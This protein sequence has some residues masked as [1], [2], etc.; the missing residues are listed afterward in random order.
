MGKVIVRDLFCAVRN[1][2]MTH[3][4]QVASVETR[5]TL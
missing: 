2:K 5:D 1:F 4:R 3:Y